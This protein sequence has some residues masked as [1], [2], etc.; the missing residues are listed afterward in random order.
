MRNF[1]HVKV[2]SAAHARRPSRVALFDL[3]GGFA[4]EG[5][6]PGAL[7][8]S[9]I[10]RL[11][12]DVGIRPAAARAAAARMVARG[13]LEVERSP[14]E[15]VYRLTAAG[16]E[17]ID[18]GRERIFAPRPTE[19][20]RRWCLVA[21]SVPE[22]H[23]EVRDR[24]RK[25]LL[26]LGFGSASPGLFISPHDLSDGVNRIAAGLSAGGWV[27]IYRAT[28]EVPEDPLVLVRRGWPELD[29]VNRRYETF[30][31]QFGR[32][33]GARAGS[34]PNPLEAF[35][36]CFTLLSEYRRCLYADPELPRE[37]LPDGWSGAAARAAFVRSHASQIEAA[38]AHFDAVRASTA[39]RGPSAKG[40]STP[41]RGRP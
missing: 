36:A 5:G 32:P 37:L 27:T 35:R 4:V 8:L 18:Q 39:G 11:C 3:Y 23:R 30:V 40:R 26:W 14:R 9:A 12:E 34:Q 20:D 15:S 10:L 13:W 38:L 19:W 29:A 28:S 31:A 41:G 33:I 6:R 17:L 2:T 16:R 25:E 7:R 24:M 1:A 21:V 22:A